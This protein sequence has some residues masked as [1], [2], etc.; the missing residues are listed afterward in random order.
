LSRFKLLAGFLALGLAIGCNAQTT[1]SSPIDAALQR[2]I[3]NQVRSQFDLS[4]DIAVSVGTRTPSQFTGYDTLPVTLSRGT[5]SQVL[6]LLISADNK[7][8]VHMTKMDLTRDPMDSISLAGRPV[9]GNPAAKVTIV[10]FDDLECPYCARMHEELFPATLD[11]Y[12]DLVKFVYKDNPI[13]EIHPWAMRASVDANCL[14]A[15]SGTVYWDFVDYVHSHTQ[16]VSGD[17]HDVQRS[18]DTLDRIARQEAT[19][20]K[21]DESALNACLSKQ[22]ETQVKA[23]SKEAE[24][25]GLE[26]TPELFINGER[27]NGVVPEDQL[28]AVIDRALRAVG[29]QPPPLPAPAAPANGPDTAKPATAPGAQNVPATAPAGGKTGSRTAAQSNPS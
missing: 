16:E 2:R 19:L 17:N 27:V 10:N 1:P 4:S 28:W 18:F 6:D 9:R 14:A 22:D 15:Q 29:E 12:K 5:K 26:G 11:R 7:T 13:T 21:L 24:D 8:L 23:S 25:L 20:G 3:E